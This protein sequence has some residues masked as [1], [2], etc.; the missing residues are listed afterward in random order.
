M[1]SSAQDLVRADDAMV[2]FLRVMSWPSTK[3]KSEGRVAA[4]REMSLQGQRLLQLAVVQQ[5]TKSTYAESTDSWKLLGWSAISIQFT[6][7]LLSLD[8]VN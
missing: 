5:D 6:S 3:D 2:T 7:R 1:L 8:D 4:A